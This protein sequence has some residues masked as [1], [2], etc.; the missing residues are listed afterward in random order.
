MI[1]SF[2]C[3]GN[4]T[5]CLYFNANISCK[6]AFFLFRSPALVILPFI[7]INTADS[8][9]RVCVNTVTLT[10]LTMSTTTCV[11]DFLKNVIE[12]V[13]SKR[14]TVWRI[15]ILRQDLMYSVRD[16]SMKNVGRVLYRRLKS[17]AVIS[18]RLFILL[19]SGTY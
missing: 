6:D 10:T 12:C 1:H 16:T 14:E 18:T 11:S 4:L 13:S 15:K 7:I 17:Y 2:K 9:R 8:C 3:I 19:S 5:F